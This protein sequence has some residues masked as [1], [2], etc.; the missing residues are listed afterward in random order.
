MLARRARRRAPLRS[1]RVDTISTDRL[2]LAL[3]RLSSDDGW[4]FEIFSTCFLA[5]EMPE[6][7]PVGGM[8]DAGRDAYLYNPADE[9]SVFVQCSVTRGWE[10]KIRETVRVLKK[11]GFNV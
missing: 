2:S 9:P 6:L 11:N 8:H 7:R 5:P 3:D 1:M 10:T 4:M